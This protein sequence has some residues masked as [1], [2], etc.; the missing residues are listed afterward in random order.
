M[1]Q[2]TKKY[3]LYLIVFLIISC[4]TTPVINVDSEHVETLSELPSK[5]V[6]LILQPTTKDDYRLNMVLLLG[7]SSQLENWIYSEH[8]QL[9][10]EDPIK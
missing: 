4:N 9:K 6:G 8:P 2:R 10:K 5:P 3:L 1:K 7:Y